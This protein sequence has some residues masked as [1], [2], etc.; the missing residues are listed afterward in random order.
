MNDWA[1]SRHPVA[2]LIGWSPYGLNEFHVLLF[3]VFRNETMVPVQP[4]KCPA[5][6]FLLYLWAHLE[7]IYDLIP[8]A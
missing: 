2:S 5:S 7:N 6:G 1:I 4:D 3:S 8:L